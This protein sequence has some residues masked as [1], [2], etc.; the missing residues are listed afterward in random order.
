MRRASLHSVKADYSSNILEVRKLAANRFA[1]AA[2]DYTN[3]LNMVLWSKAVAKIEVT[4]VRNSR[5]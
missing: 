1:C 3:F 2:S 5:L 4:S